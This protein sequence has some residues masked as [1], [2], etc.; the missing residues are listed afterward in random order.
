MTEVEESS[1]MGGTSDLFLEKSADE[2]S[3]VD[4]KKPWKIII[5]D[6]EAEVHNVTRM[7]LNDYVFEGR[8]LFF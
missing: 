3:A 5:A 6:D 7:V 4:K 2:K 1:G 8:S